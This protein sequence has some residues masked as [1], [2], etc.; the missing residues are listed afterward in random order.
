MVAMVLLG[1]S[2][3]LLGSCCVLGGW[4]GVDLS[5]WSLGH[6]YSIVGYSGWLVGCC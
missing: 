3:W 4:W 5:G 1:C 2:V 6:Y